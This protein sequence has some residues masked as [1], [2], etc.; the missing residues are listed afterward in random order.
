MARSNKIAHDKDDDSDSD[1]FELVCGRKVLKNGRRYR[2]NFNDSLP[3]YDELKIVDGEGHGGLALHRPGPRRLAD[4]GNVSKLRDQ[5]DQAYRQYDDDLS[6]A[7]QNVP[8][9][10]FGSNN[11]I[12]GQQQVGDLCTINGAPGRLV[13]DDE[14]GELV[15]MADYPSD[16]SDRRTI[17]D[18]M[19]D[20]Q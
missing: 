15:C 9:T 7:Y 10:G 16:A 11:V 20:H 18:K 5:I 17:A 6:T 8:P 12:A 2:V 14:T 19:R 4:V 1:L 3:Q 13:V